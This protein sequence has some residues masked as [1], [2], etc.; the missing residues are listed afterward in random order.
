MPSFSSRLRELR[1]EIGLT[2][3]E[4]AQAMNISRSCAASY[5]HGKREPSLELL[6]KI[7]DFFD[8]DSDYILGKSDVRQKKE[9][10]QKPELDGGEARL[11]Q[12]MDS[13]PAEKQQQ[14]LD[15]ARFLLEQQNRQA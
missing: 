4:F 3:K 13:L 10:G 11:R 2:Q 1:T 8:V 9:S 12:L 5:E 7:A 14:I 15:Y 6:S